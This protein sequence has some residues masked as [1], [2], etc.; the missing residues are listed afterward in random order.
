MA[1]NGQN[2]PI[3]EN[4]YDSGGNR[5]TLVERFNQVPGLNASVGIA[6]NVDFEI[7]GTNAA[8]ADVTYYAEGGINIATHGGASDS[9]IILPHLDAA[10]S[11]WTGVTWGSDQQT[12]W[13]CHIRIPTALTEK[14]IWCGLKLTNTPVIATDNDQAFFRFQQGTDTNWQ[15]IT[16]NNGTDTQYDTGVAVAISTEYRFWIVIDASRVPHYFINGVEVSGTAATALKD[17]TDYIPYVGLLSSTNA[18]VKALILRNQWI[19]RKVA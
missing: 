2:F 11:A 4:L 15:V 9:T 14:T 12:M 17:T 19:S 6:F 16:S 10:Q 7:L 18:T 5:Y 3:P 1:T 13:G 8:N